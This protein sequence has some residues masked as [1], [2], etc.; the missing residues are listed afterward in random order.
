MVVCYGEK[1][2]LTEFSVTRGDAEYFISG[3]IEMHRVIHRVTPL[4]RHDSYFFEVGLDR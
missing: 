3:T 1:L 2:G 4:G